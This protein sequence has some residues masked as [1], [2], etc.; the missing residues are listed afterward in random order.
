MSLVYGKWEHNKSCV[1]ENIHRVKPLEP[2]CNGEQE[3]SVLS[4]T[5]D[6][7]F[8]MYDV[9]G[10]RVLTTA[11]QTLVTSCSFLILSHN[12]NSHDMTFGAQH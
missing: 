12:T 8:R 9:Y 11:D 3:P 1:D 7:E 4:R 2:N 6:E 10:F 5:P